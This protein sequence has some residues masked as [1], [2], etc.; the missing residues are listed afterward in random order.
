MSQVKYVV[1]KQKKGHKSSGLMGQKM[2]KNMG[3]DS[4]ILVVLKKL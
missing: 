1:S 4:G 3:I 2:K